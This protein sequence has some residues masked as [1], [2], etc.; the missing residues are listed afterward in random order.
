MSSL[1]FTIIGMHCTSCAL[2]AE[3]T[4]GKLE[5]VKSVRV[6]FA[7]ETAQVEY[8]EAK[9]T[10]AQFYQTVRELGYGVKLEE[11]EEE[12]DESQLEL[13][14]SRR[15]LIVAWEFTGPLTISMLASMVWGFGPG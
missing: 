13:K 4:L 9:V 2:N 3:R 11:A 6:N 15:R 7:T 12:D 5:G 8:D 14:R 10:P 1:N